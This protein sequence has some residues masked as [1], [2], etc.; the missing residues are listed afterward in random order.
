MSGSALSVL[1]NDWIGCSGPG[2]GAGQG[3]AVGGHNRRVRGGHHPMVTSPCPSNRCRPV[4][5]AGAGEI[6]DLDSH[7]PSGAAARGRGRAAT[8]SGADGGEHG[9]QDGDGGGGDVRGDDEGGRAPEGR[10][11][12]PGPGR[13]EE[14]QG[15]APA[16]P[17]NQEPAAAQ[18]R[19]VTPVAR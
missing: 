7:P 12:I 19:P 13:G 8:L 16:R 1:A 17:P 9:E 4:V 15:H 14:H 3:A 10:R 18:A 6:R 5:A 11:V 2:A